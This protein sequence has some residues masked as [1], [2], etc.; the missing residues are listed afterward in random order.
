M[1]VLTNE[2][3]ETRQERMTEISNTSRVS[4]LNGRMSHMC[5][6][7]GSNMYMIGG[8]HKGNNSERYKE[9]DV[10]VDMSDVNIYSIRDVSYYTI[11]S[12]LDY[13]NSFLITISPKNICCYW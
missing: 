11:Y 10:T 1:T 2:F 12:K 5:A 4:I 7:I 8:Y 13:F 6:V 3:E 9:R